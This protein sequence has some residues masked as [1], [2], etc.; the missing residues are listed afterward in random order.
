[1]CLNKEIKR[2]FI[3]F[4]IVIKDLQA[5]IKSTRVQTRRARQRMRGSNTP[6]QISEVGRSIAR[7][8]T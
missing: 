4:C 6:K 8:E 1:M 2:N 3:Q 5:N 7:G